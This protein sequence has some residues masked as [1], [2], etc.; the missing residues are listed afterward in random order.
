MD[1][2]I[3]NAVRDTSVKGVDCSPSPGVTEPG[4]STNSAGISTFS[5]EIY[6]Y[7]F[8]KEKVNYIYIYLRIILQL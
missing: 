4:I 8:F 7:L 6:W 1:C 3:R 2:D 5:V